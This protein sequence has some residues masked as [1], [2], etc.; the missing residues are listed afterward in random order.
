MTD[1]DDNHVTVKVHDA[2]ISTKVDNIELQVDSPSEATISKIV[3]GKP[4][5]SKIFHSEAGTTSTAISTAIVQLVPDDWAVS[6]KDE[7]KDC[8][9]IMI[10]KVE[11]NANKRKKKDTKKETSEYSAEFNLGILKLGY[12]KIIEY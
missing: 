10:S 1:S 2:F 7:I 12:K 3:D 6:H 4:V 11:K 9:D 5:D 8:F